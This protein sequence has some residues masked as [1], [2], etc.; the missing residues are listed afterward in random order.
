MAHAKFCWSTTGDAN[1]L[2]KNDTIYNMDVLFDASQEAGP[3][4]NAKRSK[5][6]FMSNHHNAGQNRMQWQLIHSKM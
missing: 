1:L 4:V 3:K 6:M 5:Y 2:D